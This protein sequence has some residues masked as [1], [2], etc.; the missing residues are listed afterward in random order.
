MSKTI[1]NMSQF[2][3]DLSQDLK[4]IFLRSSIAN[5]VFNVNPY[6]SIFIVA[7]GATGTQLGLLTSLSLALTAISSIATGWLSDRINRKTMFL[8]GALIGVLVPLTYYLAGNLLWL[9]PA[10]VF[11]GF[12]DGII[13]PPWTAMYANSVK[14]EHRG[15]IYGVA[16]IFILAPTLFAALIGGQ[17]VNHYGGL[18]VDGIRPIYLVQLGFLLIALLTVYWKLGDRIPGQYARKLNIS[19]MIKDYKIVLSRKGVKAWVGMKSLG[20]ISIG[21]AG[22]FWILFAASVHGAS[23][24]TIS[25]M[26]TARI[27]VNILTSPLSGRLTDTIGRKWMIIYGRIVMYIATIIF[28]VLGHNE[29]FLIIAWILMGLSDST[30]VAWQAQEAELVSHVQRARM[31][32]LSVSAFNLL[33]VPASVLGG[34][35]WDSVNPLAPFI[36]MAIVDG[37]IRMP[38]VYKYVPD[39]KSLT[40]EQEPDEASL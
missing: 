19:T 21:L 31:T 11:A 8:I 29:V 3:H 16:N 23:A 26:V 33:A 30:G 27:L 32:A 18:T 6:N 36:V 15:T 39:S 2:Y 14:N 12:A 28:L 9:I 25:Y 34:W 1:K 7:L 38:I 10:F 13:A 22:P 35:L 37:F 17:L 20:S 24:I 5:F 4:I 40:T